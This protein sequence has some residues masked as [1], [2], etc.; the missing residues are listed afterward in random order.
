MDVPGGRELA[1]HLAQLARDLQAPD[2]VQDTLDLIVSAAVAEV[3][4]AEDASILAVQGRRRIRTLAASSERA[5][6]IDRAQ[7]ETGQGPCLDALFESR[8]VRTPDLTEE[9]RWPL[10]VAPAVELGAGSMLAVQL[11]VNGD[12]LGALNLVSPKTGAFGEDAEDLALLFA[13]HA[14]I[15]LARAEQQQNFEI[16]LS[17][18]DVIGQAKGILMERHKLTADE[19]FRILVQA[20]QTRHRKLREIAEELTL[21]GELPAGQS[22]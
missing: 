3:P 5:R 8:T 4:G 14:A 21:T 7:H 13:T 18:R 22:D 2:S 20:S 15:A 17:S 10:F 11:Y 12:D 19:A 1:E 16:A 9:D 6:A